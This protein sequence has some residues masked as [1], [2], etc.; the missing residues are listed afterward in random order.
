MRLKIKKRA[1]SAAGIARETTSVGRSSIV[2]CCLLAVLAR[3]KKS[4]HK[5]VKGSKKMCYMMKQKG[6]GKTKKTRGAANNVI[7]TERGRAAG[8]YPNTAKGT[9]DFSGRQQ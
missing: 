7:E 8:A 4:S 3:A 9:E 2:V 1:T 5:T 6:R